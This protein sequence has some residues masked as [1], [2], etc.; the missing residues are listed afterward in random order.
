M[1]NEILVAPTPTERKKNSRQRLS[2]GA[3]GKHARRLWTVEV[4]E[5]EGTCTVFS[6]VSTVFTFT[7][8]LPLYNFKDTQY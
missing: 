6:L 7:F 8:F 1:R 5:R 2:L 3:R 4:L